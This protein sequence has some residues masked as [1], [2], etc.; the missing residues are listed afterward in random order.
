METATA[1]EQDLDLDIE[2][3]RAALYAAL[4]R[5]EDLPRR[6]PND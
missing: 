4:A 2:T 6:F 5:I 3:E 1:T